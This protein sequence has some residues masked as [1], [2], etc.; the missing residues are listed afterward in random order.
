MKYIK[1][2]YG[3][4]NSFSSE[5]PE[6]RPIRSFKKEFRGKPEKQHDE[7]C[8]GING[9]N[10]EQ[11]KFRHREAQ[12]KDPASKPDPLSY[13]YPALISAV[14]QHRENHEDLR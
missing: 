10:P 6:Y 2:R 11:R 7:S 4:E 9:V 5:K 14:Y 1:K 13:T 12:K 3:K 8:P